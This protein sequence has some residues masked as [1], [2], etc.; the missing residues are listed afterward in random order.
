[1]TTVQESVN[2]IEKIKAAS[3]D[4]LSEKQQ[5]HP[6]TIR[7]VYEQQKI[8]Y[9]TQGDSVWQNGNADWK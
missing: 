2:T 5:M 8:M 9:D 3:P 1:M 4:I 7:R 6:E